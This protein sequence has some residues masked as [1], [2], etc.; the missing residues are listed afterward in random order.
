MCT[1]KCGGL[2]PVDGHKGELAKQ[3]TSTDFDWLKI[4]KF[5]TEDVVEWFKTA[6]PTDDVKPY[7]GA[8]ETPVV[9][10]AAMDTFKI[11]NQ[12]ELLR[13]TV[14]T[15]ADVCVKCNHIRME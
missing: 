3:C 12:Q 14:F 11:V 6:S 7:E 4:W 15:I 8:A 1:T 13:L 2:E 9:Y 10:S 5:V